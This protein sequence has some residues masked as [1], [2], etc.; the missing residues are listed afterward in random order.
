MTLT[1]SDCFCLA[2]TAFA[3]TQVF[4]Q[5]LVSVGGFVLRKVHSRAS[6]DDYDNDDDDGE[7]DDDEDSED[8]SEISSDTFV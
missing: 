2:G 3:L 6:P 7:D 1:T 5:L 8:R 4:Y